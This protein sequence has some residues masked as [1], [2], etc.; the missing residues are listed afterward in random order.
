MKEGLCKRH[1]ENQVKQNHDQFKDQNKEKDVCAIC[2][3]DF[4]D[5][6]MLM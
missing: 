2:L 5:K 3:E 6:T 4:V 1:K